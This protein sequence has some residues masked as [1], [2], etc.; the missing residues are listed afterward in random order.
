MFA[1]LIVVEILGRSLK[2]A[3]MEADDL[4]RSCDSRSYWLGVRVN[5]QDENKA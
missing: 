5:L 4:W 1:R 3:V 2:H